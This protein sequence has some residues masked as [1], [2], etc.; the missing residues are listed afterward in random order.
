MTDPRN[1]PPGPTV[2]VTGASAGFGV[3]IARRFAATGA[4]VIV[5]ARR[6]DRLA[7][8]TIELGANAH[9]LP[10]DLRDRAAVEHAIGVLPPAFAAI[11]V[12]VNNAGL[13]KGLEPAQRAEL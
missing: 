3:A 8:L 13:A 5:S 2:L 6:A 7:T 9:V 12:L 11:D 1:R 4:R 10:L